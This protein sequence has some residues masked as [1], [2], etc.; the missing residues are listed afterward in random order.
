MVG[1]LVWIAA[2]GLASIGDAFRGAS[3]RLARNVDDA[4]GWEWKV[5][6]RVVDAMERIEVI[7]FGEV[8]EIDDD[9]EEGTI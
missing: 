2:K 9:D 1:R 8:I 4:E 5:R 3:A 6:E 7:A